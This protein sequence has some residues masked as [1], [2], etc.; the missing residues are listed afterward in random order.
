MIRPGQFPYLDI[1]PN[2]LVLD[3]GVWERALKSLRLLVAGNEPDQGVYVKFFQIPSQVPH[4]GL[5]NAV[6]PMALQH[7][8]PVQIGFFAAV[9]V[10]GQNGGIDT[11]HNPG[12]H[13]GQKG[14][15]IYK[16]GVRKAVFHGLPIGF[17][18]FPAPE[19]LLLP[20]GQFEGNAVGNSLFCIWFNS[21][22]HFISLLYKAF[23]D[24]EGF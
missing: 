10:A 19:I 18:D 4:Q 14:N 21:D 20:Q 9:K 1:N 5:G 23:P 17:V 11:T 7:A 6:M 24:R 15:G 8:N 13:I 16:P 12:I 3:F 22:F 2:S